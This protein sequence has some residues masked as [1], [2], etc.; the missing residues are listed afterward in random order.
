MNASRLSM[1]AALAAA[2]LLTA[3]WVPAVTV[4]D[5][6]GGMTC[7]Y[8][9]AAATLA[10]ERPGGDWRDAAGSMHGDQAYDTADI[11]RSK[12]VQTVDWDLTA[13]AR[14]WVSGRHLPAAV[15]LRA[16]PGGTSGTVVF[17]S[18]EHDNAAERPVLN[19]QWSDGSS[20]RHVPVADTHFSC[21]N[22]KSSGSDPILKV[23][24][25]SAAYVAMAIEPRLGH[26][27]RKATLVMT[28]SKLYGAGARVGAF[29]GALPG[30]DGPAA[31]GGLAAGF[32]RDRGLERHPDVLFSERFDTSVGP[33]WLSDKD[34]KRL[35]TVSSDRPNRFEP[36][37]GPALAVTLQSGSTQAMNS[38][39]RFAQAGATE[40]DE[41]YF[42]YYLRLGENW[43]PT[44][45]GG[46]L[47]GLAGT[48]GRS[49][50]GA[51]KSDGQN[52]WS[53]RGAFFQQTAPPSP[54]AGL[55]ALG[56][57]VYHAGM[58]K[59]TYGETWGWNLGP[60]GLLEKNRWYSVEQHVRLNTPGRSDGVLQAWID[61]QLVFSRTDLRYRDTEQLKIESVW[62][63][64]YHGGTEPAPQDMTLYI[65]N[66]VVAR[67]YIGPAR[68]R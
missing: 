6:P 65:D 59:R 38:H 66:L 14:D 62:M 47:P 64:V 67:R 24:R 2:L 63:N 55:R 50:W 10:W 44:R 39:L 37:D 27:L 18:R 21:P 30:R 51:R 45:D 53:T 36:M 42:R 28:T 58:G 11:R 12:V 57:Y 7:Q 32:V 68:P 61:G 5:G 54:I 25:G 1:R 40:P 20:T 13:L 17:A 23:G 8:Y 43:D 3:T 19:V 29:S 60:T 22:Y 4:E 46:K 31:Q 34:D 49:G 15:V 56:S 26:T 9:A 33:A 35:R 52:G 41:A 48:Y 16:V